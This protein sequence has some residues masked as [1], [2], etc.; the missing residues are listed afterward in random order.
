ML[1]NERKKNEEKEKCLCISNESSH[2]HTMQRK[3]RDGMATISWFDL[4]CRCLWPVLS[5]PLAE[6]SAVPLLCN[7]LLLL[8][9][10]TC[11]I[12]ITIYMTI[13]VY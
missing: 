1:E 6:P 13:D 2:Q 12:R 11:I 5:A 9:R 4:P 7:I 10:P 8:R 3:M